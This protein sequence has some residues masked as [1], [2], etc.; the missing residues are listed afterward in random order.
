MYAATGSAGWHERL[1]LRAEIGAVRGMIGVRAVGGARNGTDATMETPIVAKRHPQMNLHKLTRFRTA[2]LAVVAG[3][4][5]GLSA[6]A[7]AAFAVGDSRSV[8]APP[9]APATVSGRAPGP[10]G[11]IPP[12]F[13]PEH[14]PPSAAVTELQVVQ[15]LQRLAYGLDQ[16]LQRTS[17]DLKGCTTTCLR[18]DAPEALSGMFQA[19]CQGVE[20]EALMLATYP[21]VEAPHTEFAR[22]A[23]A[24]CADYRRQAAA[25]GLPN[26]TNA[27][28][29]A[30]ARRMHASLAPALVVASK[31]SL[32]SENRP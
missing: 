8:A 25:L 28:W 31:W 21:D 5:V 27:R 29:V 23:T 13:S 26:P 14:P 15:E 20:T 16:L 22:A 3:V 30:E 18:D 24:V 10:A 1:S 32:Q 9:P 12:Q 6:G 19:V 2:G 17:G 4:A 11:Q 7:I